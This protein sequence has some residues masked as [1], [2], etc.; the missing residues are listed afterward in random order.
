MTLE[1]KTCSSCRKTY[2]GPKEKN[3]NIDRSKPD[4]FNG[5]CK[6]CRKLIHKKRGSKWAKENHPEKYKARY[7]LNNAIQS[8]KIVKPN[9]CEKCGIS[10]RLH[11]HHDDYQKPLDVVFVCDP[12]HKK[13]HEMELT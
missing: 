3:F 9:K 6:T 8:G 11:G 7:T 13:T 4:G 12:C 10:S 5:T 1:E 2:S